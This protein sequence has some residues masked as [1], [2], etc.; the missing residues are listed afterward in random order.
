MTRDKDCPAIHTQNQSASPPG[1]AG[2][3][4]RYNEERYDDVP[5]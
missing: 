2:N 5:F 1:S 4:E 3:E